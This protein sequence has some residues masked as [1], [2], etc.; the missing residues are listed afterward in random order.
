[1]KIRGK[2][3]TSFGILVSAMLLVFAVLTDTIFS[4]SINRQRDLYFASKAAGTVSQL[5]GIMRS[6]LA[7][8]EIFA[9]KN[10]L[11]G[12]ALMREAAGSPKLAEQFSEKLR[13]DSLLSCILCINADGKVIKKSGASSNYDYFFLMKN[14]VA[15]TIERRASVV[16]SPAVI[17]IVYPLYGKN[18]ITA[19]GMLV[20]EIGTGSLRKKLL[21]DE[22][23]SNSLL[24]IAQNGIT[25]F[26]LGEI[27]GV[28]S[29]D[30]PLTAFKNRGAA[31]NADDHHPGYLRYA[32]VLC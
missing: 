27:D 2:L 13:K 23:V 24:T 22:N 17:A 19:A 7:D 9:L 4:S 16:A 28:K 32:Y 18:D 1:M 21:S 31:S 10:D 26:S 6:Y 11:D 8:I 14:A 25:L 5:N 30:I 3:I 29:G 15:K 12:I 20:Y